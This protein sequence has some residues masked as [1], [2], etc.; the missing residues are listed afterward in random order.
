M[1]H[2]SDLSIDAEEKRKDL[3]NWCYHV[4]AEL[5]R[6][7]DTKDEWIHHPRWL[8]TMRTCLSDHPPQHAVHIFIKDVLL[9]DEQLVA[10][11]YK[12]EYRT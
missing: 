5:E 6:N 7:R 4:Y 9:S 12:P 1:G 10:R 2:F 3:R 11:G 8:A